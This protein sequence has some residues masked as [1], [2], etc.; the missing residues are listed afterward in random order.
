MDTLFRIECLLSSI[1]DKVAI[2]QT[3]A[4]PSF[5][6]QIGVQRLLL[7]VKIV[8]NRVNQRFINLMWFEIQLFYPRRITS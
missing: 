8:K 6:P 4:F 3:G 1:L 5:V 7:N 2:H